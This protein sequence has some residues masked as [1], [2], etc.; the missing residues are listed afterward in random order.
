MN[1]RILCDFDG[2]ISREDVTDSV[3]ERFAL[4]GWE[5]IEDEW[6]AGSIGSRECMLRQ[7]ELIRASQA[8]FDRHLD[9]VEIDPTFPAFVKQCRRAGVPLT[10]V[11]DGLDYSIRRVLGR[12]GLDDLP[13]MANHLDI[14]GG[15]RYRLAFPYANEACVG[16]SGTCKC[17]IAENKPGQRDL[18]LLI[19]DGTSD[20]CAASS[21]DMV[22]AKDKLLTH[23]R[24]RGLPFVAFRDFA[25][26]SRLLATLLD[27]PVRL[28][29]KAP[30][31][32]HL[33]NSVN[34]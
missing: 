7:V 6:K 15:G 30:S 20:M 21:V 13:I 26:V 31:H 2:T 19:G 23:C 10:V 28:G 9:H 1:W 33:E 11:S 27:E 16:A 34:E 17:K 22:F 5:D 25:Q 3:L 29:F 12:H 18:R 14:L 4:D 32:M 8:D 24:E